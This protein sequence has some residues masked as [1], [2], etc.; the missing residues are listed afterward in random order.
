MDMIG[1]TL[2][3]NQIESIP[4]YKKQKKSKQISDKTRC[5][6]NRLL[7]NFKKPK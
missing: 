5:E 7:L 2:E 1:R 3:I 6:V 4:T